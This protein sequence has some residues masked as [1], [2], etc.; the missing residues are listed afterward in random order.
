[1]QQ[2]G[3]GHD[4]VLQGLGIDQIA[5]RQADAFILQRLVHG[6]ETD[7]TICVD[8]RCAYREV[9]FCVEF[10]GVRRVDDACDVD[11]ASLKQQSLGTGLRYVPDNDAPH[12]RCPLP[13]VAFVG[14]KYDGFV[15]KPG[16]QAV[17]VN[18]GGARRKPSIAE[19]VVNLLLQ[20]QYPVERGRRTTRTSGWAGGGQDRFSKSF[21]D[22]FVGIAVKMH[23]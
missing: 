18:T 3:V 6:I 10:G 8:R 20:K 4:A 11:V 13:A 2:A 14:R 19:I 9:L 15:G 17:G 23:P 21:R 1:M 16:L 5:E 22:A 12:V 7:I